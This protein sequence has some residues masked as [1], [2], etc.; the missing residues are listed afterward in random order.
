VLHDQ[1]TGDKYVP[2]SHVYPGQKPVRPKTLEPR[3]AAGRAGGGSRLSRRCCINVQPFNSPPTIQPA[4]RPWDRPP[5][6]VQGSSPAAGGAPS[7][8]PAAPPLRPDRPPQKTK[9]PT[10]ARD[11]RLAGRVHSDQLVAERVRRAGLRAGVQHGEPQLAGAVGGAVRRLRQHGAGE[12]PLVPG[13]GREGRCRCFGH[14]L[15]PSGEG[16]G[17]GSGALLHPAWARGEGGRRGERR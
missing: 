13:A 9:P 5:G 8:N 1:A 4:P 2:I 7:R 15:P 6:R 14:W 3:L 17:R 11:S 16:R 10:P 12:R